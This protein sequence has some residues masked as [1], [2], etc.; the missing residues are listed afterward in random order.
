MSIFKSTI[1]P[2][3]AAQLKARE[4]IVSSPN[5]SDDFL[6]Y[7]S[8]KNSWVRMTSFVNYNDPKGKYKGDELS[9]KYVLEGGTLYETSNNS[10]RLRSGVAKTAG[11]YA[12]DLDS[13]NAAGKIDKNNQLGF[14]RPFGF[15]PMPGITNVSVMNKSAYGSLREAT[16]QF[17]AWDKH[18]LEELEILFM[19]TGYTVFL[20]WGWSQYIDHDPAGAKGINSEPGNIKVKNFD[21]TTLNP[22]SNKLN[23]ETV[24]EKIDDVVKNTK[25][26]YDAMLGFIKNFSWQLMPNGGFQCSTTL[27]SRGEAIDS[28]KAS[29]N[30]Y[31]ILGSNPDPNIAS[32]I[33]QPQPVYSLFEKIFL[34]IIGHANESEYLASYGTDG[35]SRP[36]SMNV[37][38]S[39][40]AQINE[41]QNQSETVYNLIKSELAATPFKGIDANGNILKNVRI[42]DLDQH[43]C[44]KF[45]DG[46]GE[47]TAV[48]YI[49]MNAFLAILNKFFILKDKNTTI[50]KGIHPPVVSILLPQ[51]VPCLA[52]EDS[53]SI[54]VSTCL[55]RNSKA[56]LVCDNNS[57]FI[58]DVYNRINFTNITTDHSSYQTSGSFDEFIISGNNIGNIANIFIGINHIVKRY[59]ELSGSP[60]GVDVITLLQTIL[61]DI[62]FALGGINDFKLY[63]SRNVVQIIDVK[64][65]G[66]EKKDTKFKFDLI[67]LK[68]ICRDVKINSRVFA[69]QATM[70]AIGATS[71]GY[72]NNLG[73]IYSSTQAHFNKG[74]TDRILTTEYNT[75]NPTI[76]TATAPDGTTVTGPQTFYISLY[77]QIVSISSYIRNNVLGERSIS[78]NFHT[79]KLPS[80]ADVINAGSLLKTLHYQINGKDVDFKALIPFEL[81]ITL[82]GIGGFIV[83]QIFRIDKSILPKDYDEKNL[84]FIITGISHSL[85]NNDWTTTVK[86]QIC[87]L[88][89]DSVK[90][91]AVDKKKLRGTLSNIKTSA[92]AE[93]LILCA[94]SDFMVH[95]MFVYFL[96]DR[97]NNEY[98]GSQSL[99]DI[100]AGD[101]V[102]SNLSYNYNF[103]N[104][105]D[106]PNWLKLIGTTTTKPSSVS[107]PSAAYTKYSLQG[108]TE[109]FDG[110]TLVNDP[111]NYARRG[112][113]TI[114]TVDK[115][116][117]Y[118]QNWYNIQKND[119]RNIN[120]PFF[121]NDFNKFITAGGTY[122]FDAAKFKTL[123]EGGADYNKLF[124]AATQNDPAAMTDAWNKF[125]LGKLGPY[126][127]PVTSPIFIRKGSTGKLPVEANPFVVESVPTSADKPYLSAT[128]I[129][130]YNNTPG[131]INK[132]AVHPFT[133]DKSYN[134][135][136]GRGT[137]QIYYEGSYVRLQPGAFLDSFGKF[138]NFLFTNRAVLGMPNINP[139]AGFTATQYNLEQVK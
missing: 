138:Y 34:N 40:Y 131:T 64:Y 101:K 84:G 61:D 35:I 86:T 106:D 114:V 126:N 5:R 109:E 24:Y 111:Y 116:L 54:D 85:Q 118:L 130:Q 80:Q 105:V 76:L 43:T 137:A 14:D 110:L 48:E 104:I 102:Y 45:V 122:T 95:Q 3:I 78:P 100:R 81:E 136:G 82:D 22:F 47:G 108:S 30:P 4:S 62:S 128:D 16:I 127:M 32:G 135:P 90:G 17:Y 50:S 23:E 124:T 13:N 83:G 49:S 20:E 89:N 18:Q 53:V 27:I 88:E 55:I 10:F 133:I 103:G 99:L 117:E 59:R 44:I 51:G 74:L 72:T 9:K 57:G 69:E 33:E 98:K 68:S 66:N 31:T 52:S 60:S 12:S 134:Q 56:T 63:N 79:T 115:V 7:T 6:R 87:I 70:M 38:G 75:A 139:P 91:F 42:S 41:L 112:F 29:A 119:P 46:S 92:F 28:I 11:I 77:N 15:R 73:D 120:D 39:S 58:P 2:E 121:P 125:W 19:R 96:L 25:G 65:F 132:I 113:S 123:L 93:G 67:G 8:G 1:S 129:N 36:G 37:P 21:T 71:A 94:L 97:A 107:L 26:N